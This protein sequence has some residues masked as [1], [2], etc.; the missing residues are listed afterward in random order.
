M[1]YRFHPLA[2]AEHYEA[3]QFYES[4]SAGLGRDYLSEFEQLMD[5][6]VEAPHRCRIERKP[7]VRRATL[8]RFPYKVVYREFEA[9]IQILAVSHKRRRP[10]YWASRL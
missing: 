6:V 1:T 5:N 7:D 8:R 2:E 9:H 10:G 4:R 3:I